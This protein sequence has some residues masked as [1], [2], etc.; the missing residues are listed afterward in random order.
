MPMRRRVQSPLNAG[1]RR[2]RVD[3]RRNLNN[4]PSTPDAGLILDQEPQVGPGSDRDPAT[5]PVTSTPIYTTSPNLNPFPPDY[6]MLDHHQMIQNNYQHHMPAYT[7]SPQ[8][9]PPPLP[10]HLPQNTPNWTTH[11]QYNLSQHPQGQS[12]QTTRE[13]NG[14][15]HFRNHDP[16]SR[17]R[18]S[19][20]DMEMLR[21]N[22]S[23]IRGG[24]EWL[25]KALTPIP[26]FDGS[27]IPVEEFIGD[28][29]IAVGT[30]EEEELDKFRYLLFEKLSGD[31][32]KQIHSKR[33]RY[34]S[35][36]DLLRD[37]RA[38]YSIKKS[39]LTLKLDLANIA[40]GSKE[41]I[42]D[43]AARV[44]EI[45]EILDRR[46]TEDRRGES[47]SV[48]RILSLENDSNVLECFVKGLRDELA[49]Y[50]WSKEPRSLENAISAAH[51]AEELNRSR[52]L[53][54]LNRAKFDSEREKNSKKSQKI[55]G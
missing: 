36:T 43:Y 42:S 13:F 27:N 52:A 7:L 15:G 30:I 14:N 8:N 31:A 35:I 45:G 4:R 47:T 17:S 48:I 24:P 2:D 33:A 5:I 11:P 19:Q 39:T 53:T 12:E 49:N 38:L 28:V 9:N 29:Q 20:D 10:N 26:E 46:I 50:V 6:T 25:E 21:H 44:K 32:R 55:V 22:R 16:D 18:A 40:Q 54:K 34:R 23:T 51:N 1:D 37:L 3:A 41:S